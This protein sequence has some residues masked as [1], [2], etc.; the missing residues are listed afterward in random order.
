MWTATFIGAFPPML[1]RYTFAA[2]LLVPSLVTAQVPQ[3]AA[4]YDA[5]KAT[6][7]TPQPAVRNLA[8]PPIARP[9][10]GRP[11]MRLLGRAGQQLRYGVERF[12]VER[13]R[14]QQ[15]G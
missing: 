7:A 13:R 8:P 14:D 15:Y 10:R 4:A 1:E 6:L 12:D 11:D 2:L 9:K 5:W 3:D